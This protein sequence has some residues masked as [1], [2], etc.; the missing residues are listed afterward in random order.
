[1][2]EWPLALI[3]IAIGVAVA[4]PVGP[5]NIMC[6]HRVVRR[7]MLSG[8][9]AGVGAMTA[10]TLYAAVAAFGISAISGFI[11]GN[12]ETLKLIGSLILVV[13]GL[14][15]ALRRP[16]AEDSDERDDARSM[17]RSV[18]AAFVLAATNPALL[19]GFLA[20][21]GGLTDFIETPLSLS[22]ASLLVAGVAVGSALWWVVL[23][24]LVSWLRGRINDS[25]LHSLNVLLGI[26]LIVFGVCV[27]LSALYELFGLSLFTR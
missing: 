16:H 6:I 14:N 26:G 10:D 22:G 13:F 12:F 17:I 7:G 27:F 8:L 18:L 11:E 25:W 20:I 1:M 23:C 5:V 9:A 15:V 3:G 2:L 4:A 24:S 21:F 19:L